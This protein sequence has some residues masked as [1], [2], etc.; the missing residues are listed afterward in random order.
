MRHMWETNSTIHCCCIISLLLYWAIGGCYEVVIAVT[1]STSG[2]FCMRFVAAG[3]DKSW[4]GFC[5]IQA[6][7]RYV[8]DK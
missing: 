6:K 8:G 4:A 3:F 1:D 5:Q 7:M 2:I